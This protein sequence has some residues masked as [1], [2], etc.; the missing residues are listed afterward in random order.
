[1]GTNTISG[2]FTASG[3]P[4]LTGL[5]AGT[6]VS[7]LGLDS[8]NHLV[9]NAA[10][11]GAGG[12]GSGT[13][14]GV[15]GGTAA[16]ALTAS[17]VLG[18]GGA[19]SSHAIRQVKIGVISGATTFTLDAIAN[20]NSDSCVRFEDAAANVSGSNTVTITANAAD[21]IGGGSTGGSVGPFITPRMAVSFCV[22][23]THNWTMQDSTLIAATTA[24]SHQFFNAISNVG[25]FNY[26]QPVIADVANWGT[27]V[28]SALAAT[29]NGASGPIGSLTPTNNNCVV[30][31]GSAWTSTAC[32]GGAT[33]VGVDGGTAIATVT[34]TGIIGN[35]V[36][37]VN[38]GTGWATG[39]L[40]LP[41]ISAIISPT[42][43]CIRIHDGGNF[44]DG[45]HTLTITAN[46]ADKI[47][48]GSTGGSIG[49][50]TVA[51][52]GLMLCS[53]KSSTNSNWNVLVNT[54]IPNLS[55]AQIFVG[56][57][58]DLPAAVAM[59]QDCTISNAGVMTCLKTN[60]VSFG[61]AATANTGTSGATLPLLNGTNTWS[62]TQTFGTVLGTVNT[63]SGTTYTLAATDCG[64]TILF[65]NASAITLTTLNSLTPGCSIAVEQGAAGQITVANGSGAT[66]TSAHS[67]TKTFNAVGAIIGLFVDT[68]TG[69][70]AHFVLTGDGA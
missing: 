31:S 34:G 42:T 40:T 38:I 9:L 32:P 28:A 54:T 1:M 13:G 7:C 45:T 24:P 68:G 50:F 64:K 29:L 41:A 69:A 56:N 55:S 66:L 62:G 39:V 2:N 3:V 46:A 53:S 37:Q 57:S 5:S 10:A 59:S 47:N 35:S 15:D 30:G 58:S 36:E 25:V 23:A 43:G 52:S 17:C 26:A 63:Q 51:G 12:G 33:G 70:N 60:N 4:I 61:T 16:V 21:A 27:G 20:V 19:C 6:Q 65:T 67:Y 48:G 49:P 18:T 14:F 11:C 44:V 22:T 8:G